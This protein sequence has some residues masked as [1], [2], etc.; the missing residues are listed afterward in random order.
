ME[1]YRPIYKIGKFAFNSAHT[2]YFAVGMW[3]HRV[4]RCWSLR[5]NSYLSALG[6]GG[7]T[8]L[9]QFLTA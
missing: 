6:N 9:A 1:K 3:K 7:E 5:R 2:I 8:S 4:C